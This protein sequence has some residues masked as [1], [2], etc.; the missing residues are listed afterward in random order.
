MFRDYASFNGEKL[1]APRPT[2]NLKDRPLSAVRDCLFNIFV[3]SLRIGDRSSI[4]NPR[5]RHAVV[6]RTY[7][8]IVAE[9]LSFVCL[10][11]WSY[12]PFDCIFHS[13]VAGFSL[14]ILEVSLSH[15]TTRH[16]RY[17]SPGRVISSSQRPLLDN[18]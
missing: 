1:S 6:T 17:D 18:T 8:L 13:P 12:N 9:G 2:P 3:A 15:T 11:S 4:R 14:L 10:F 16:S 7:V 5:T